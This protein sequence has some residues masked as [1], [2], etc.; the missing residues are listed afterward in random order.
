[1]HLSTAKTSRTGKSPGFFY[2]SLTAIEKK[3]LGGK[4]SH[5][6]MIREFFDRIWNQKKLQATGEMFETDA[7]IH[8]SVS[9][10]KGVEAIQKMFHSWIVA[11]PDLH[12][13]VE[14]IISAGDKAACR[15]HGTGTH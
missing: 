7:V 4:M 1:M 6:K 15:F 3:G 9:D 5:E 12:Y 2:L 11:F 13:K 8:G 10:F 14:E